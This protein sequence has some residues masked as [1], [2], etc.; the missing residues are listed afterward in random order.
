[1]GT[2]D[3]WFDDFMMMKI[4][5]DDERRNESSPSSGGSDSGCL[6]VVLGVLAI[7]WVFAKLIG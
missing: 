1:M 2:H 5:E 6:P 7:L 4:M 3:D